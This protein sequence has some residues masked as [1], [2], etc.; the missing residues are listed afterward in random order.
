MTDRTTAPNYEHSGPPPYVPLS[1]GAV[2]AL[3]LT[4]VAFFIGLV[5]PWWSEAVPLLI[6]VMCWGGIS[7]GVRRG[8]VVAIIALVLAVVAFGLS[9]RT[10]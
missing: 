8:R 10:T 6:V 5:G 1:G 7:R 2:T 3:V 4:F 9:A